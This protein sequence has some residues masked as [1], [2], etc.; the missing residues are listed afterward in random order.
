MEHTYEVGTAYLE[1][2]GGTK[3]YETVLI[4]EGGI[5]GVKSDTA[6][7][8]KR[9]GAIAEKM[10]GGQTKIHRGS[11]AA[12]KAEQDKILHDKMRHRSGKGVYRLATPLEWGFQKYNGDVLSPVGLDSVASEHYNKAEDAIAI[13]GFFGIENALGDPNYIVE[14][15]QPEEPVDRGAQWASW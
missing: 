10:G 4:A 11:L 6:I 5:G 9:W 15:A 13:T 14:D 12:M 8:I 2:D 1:H 7:L 3:F